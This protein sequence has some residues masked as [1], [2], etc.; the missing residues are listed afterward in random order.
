M[1]YI[2]WLGL[3]IPEADQELVRNLLRSQM[4]CLPVFLSEHRA[5]EFEK[6]CISI[7]RPMFHLSV[8]V[9]T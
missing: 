6:I 2:G 9:S 7:I 1:W 3:E 8:P 5:A 4:R